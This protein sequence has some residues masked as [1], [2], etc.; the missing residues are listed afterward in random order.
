MNDPFKLNLKGL[1]ERKKPEAEAEVAQVDAA[2]D[3]MGFVSREPVAAPVEEVVRKRGRPTVA[4]TADQKRTT[5]ALPR[6][7]AKAYKLWL[8]END[9]TLQDHLEGFITE[10]VLK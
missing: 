7:V 9:M 3:R 2:G 8:A 6:D 5:F 10:L 1:R 4:R